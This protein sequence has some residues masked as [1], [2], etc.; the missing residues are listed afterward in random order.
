M[1]RRRRRQQHRRY[2]PPPTLP[3]T[4]VI[5]RATT[6]HYNHNHQ[7]TPATATTATA[8]ISTNP[9]FKR[10]VGPCESLLAGVDLL[11]ACIGT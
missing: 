6:A 5:A 3:N 10:T 4:A 11:T 8:T 1:H 7:T 9:R 2:L